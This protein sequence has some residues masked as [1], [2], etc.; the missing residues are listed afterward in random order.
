MNGMGANEDGDTFLDDDFPDIPDDEFRRLEQDAITFTQQEQA[1]STRDVGSQAAVVSHSN[2]H[3]LH[4]S[5]RQPGNRNH[6]VLAPAP[7]NV[8]HQSFDSQIIDEDGIPLVM[9]E[10][11]AIPVRRLPDEVAQREQWRLNRFAQPPAQKL[12]SGPYTSARQ[13]D[14][15]PT[16]VQTHGSKPS[17]DSRSRPQEHTV[18][19]ESHGSA[20]DDSLRRKITELLR[21][22]EE[23]TANLHKATEEIF[24]R[25][26]EIANIRAKQFNEEKTHQRE[27]AALNK[28]K[29]EEADKHAAAVQAM[30]AEN[31]K[32]ASEIQFLKQDLKEETRKAV[33][34]QRQLKE[35][36]L[37]DK[38]TNINA[39]PK[40]NNSLRD[41]FDDDEMMV[42]SPVKS[43]RRS[44]QGTPTANRKR[45]QPVGNEASIPPLA[46]R[47]SGSGFETGAQAPAALA[48]A[49][50]FS[51]VVRKDKAAERH[52]RLIQKVMSFRPSRG[53]EVLVERLVNFSFPSDKSK[54]FGTIVIE[55]SAKLEGQRLAGDFLQIF[56]DVWARAVKEKYYQCLQVLLEVVNWILELD[57]FI[58][59]TSILSNILPLLQST[60]SINARAHF[61]LMKKEYLTDPSV[62]KPTIDANINTTYCL[63]ILHTVAC[64]SSDDPNLIGLFWRSIDTDFILMMLNWCQPIPDMTLILQILATSILKDTFGN[65]CGPSQ[66]SR[67]ERYICDRI[68]YLLWELPKVDS[69]SPAYSRKQICLLRL[70]SLNLLA[71]LTLGSSINPFEPATAYNHGTTFLANHPHAMARLVRSIYDELAAAYLMTSTQ[72]LHIQ[73]VN[74]A[75]RILHFVTFS[76]AGREIDLQRR[77]TGVNGGAHKY[78]VVMARLAFAEGTDPGVD[79]G[80]TEDTVRMATE[81]LEERITPDEVEDLTRIFEG[82]VGS[83]GRRTSAI[84]S[85]QS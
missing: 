72:S 68:C 25:R 38:P 50:H 84:S 41:G 24:L 82:S 52:L 58:V 60:A 76:P 51:S 83:G 46:L 67:M 61:N 35:K 62:S 53:T 79:A 57:P 11:P 30:T 36:P 63:S 69:N 17:T 54:T 80:I 49:D 55:T 70:E 45:K 71:Q 59:D 19:H 32:V 27:L 48:K 29:Q 66:Q 18:Q 64:L 78:R 73:L 21:D 43:G 34:F 22:R 6:K 5:S 28:L 2:S 74:T 81:M 85:T 16:Y 3:G 4:S 39:T 65:I 75:M 1:S 26:G 10:L 31:N 14:Q 77:L 20:G 44:K 7:T 23:L 47:L 12:Q 56:L 33:T 13:R 8:Q 40:R 15:R 37:I 42:I 9:E